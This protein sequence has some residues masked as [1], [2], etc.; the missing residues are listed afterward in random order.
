MKYLEQT[1]TI[2]LSVRNI[3]TLA[4]KLDDPRSARTLVSSCGQV[5]V[6]AVEDAEITEEQTAAARSERLVIV[7]RSQL[8][9]L[10]VGDQVRVAEFTM[11]PVPDSAHYSDRPAGVVYM[12]SSGEHL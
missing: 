11:V 3:H 7:T 10:A 12:P 9:L 8:G 6:R 5:A 2:E 4:L 1:Q